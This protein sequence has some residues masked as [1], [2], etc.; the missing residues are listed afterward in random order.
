LSLLRSVCPEIEGELRPSLKGLKGALIRGYLPQTWV[1]RT[2]RETVT[3][4][5]D[6]DGSASA[7]AGGAEEPDVV[8][9]M[10]HELLTLA[11]ESRES[12]EGDF[13]PPTI[14]YGTRKGRT[15]FKFLRKKLGL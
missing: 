9:S 1:F 14:E 6:D 12:P 8:I 7:K 10:D 4:R 11:L 15:A 5:V 13:E 3:L 2:E